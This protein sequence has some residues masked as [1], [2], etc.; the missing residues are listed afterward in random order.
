MRNMFG[1][2]ILLEIKD[3]VSEKLNRISRSMENVQTEAERTARTVDNLGSQVDSTSSS[4][5]NTTQAFEGLGSAFGR[6]DSYS[7]KL[8]R[9]MQKLA[10]MMG[11]DVPES[12]RQ[13]YQEMFNLQREV[14]R[15]RRAF[16]AYSH[17]AMEARN[18]LAEFGLGLDDATFKQVYMRSQLGLNEHQLHA[19]ANSI[20]LNARMIKLMGSETEILTKRMQGLQRHGIKPE[21]MLPRSTIGQFQMLNETMKASQQPINMLNAG[22][23]RFGTTMEKHIKSWSAQKTAIRLAQ[24][25]MV[26]YG[27][28]LRGLTA[29]TAN[30]A[31]AFPLVGMGALLA[32]G[33]LFKVTMNANKGLQD[34]ADTTK[35]KLLKAFEPLIDVTAKFLEVAMKVVGKVAD[36]ISAFNEAH[37][38]IAKVL[39]VIG[40]LAPAM[41]LLLLPLGLGVGLIN[42]WG[43]A[44]N[45]LWTFIGPVV[46]MIGTASA[47]FLTF[48]GIVG[49]VV[50]AIGYLWK[51]CEGFRK[52]I[53]SVASTISGLVTGAF[54]SLKSAVEQVVQAFNEGGLSGALS[55]TQELFQAFV[56]KIGNEAPKMIENGVKF[57]TSFLQGLTQKL[58]EI[59]TKAHEMVTKITEGIT[60][61]L[62][63]IMESAVALIQAWITNMSNNIPMVVDCG[64]AII[65]A[66]MDGIAQVAPLWLDTVLQLFT[67][68][69]QILTENLP[70][71]LDCGIQILQSL[72]NGILQNIPMIIDAVV[73]ILNSFTLLI[74]QNLPMLI[75]AG[76]QILQG[77][78]NAI[79]QNLPMLID[80]ALQLLTTIVNAIVQNLPLLINAGLQ[81]VLTLLNALVNNGPQLMQAGVQLI[82]SVVN[83]IVNSLPQI[84][85]CAIQVVTSLLT[86]IIQNAPR[87]LMGGIQL[88]LSLIKGLQQAKSQAV[89][90]MGQVITQMIQKIPSFLG[91]MGSMG[92]QLVQGLAKGIASGA[93]AVVSAIG[94]VV[95]GAIEAGK[96]FLGIHSPSR[97]FR[98]MIGRFIPQGMAVGIKA[99][100]PKVD[101]AVM[102]MTTDPIEEAQKVVMSREG[103]IP[104]PIVT[105]PKGTGGSTNNKEINNTF[106]VNITLDGETK[107]PKEHARQIYEE[108]KRLQNLDDSMN[109]DVNP[110]ELI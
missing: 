42:G 41:T 101:D 95:Q 27:I 94:N 109:Y 80:C 108:L 55:K 43:V 107:D 98:D 75:E 46:T 63:L 61:N 31:L 66:L 25:D 96:K 23:R 69:I 106:H 51:N 77:L 44:L 8:E 1:I 68:F 45:A 34:L 12:T 62:P 16:G 81:I 33:T 56:I 20:K 71:L 40:F 67:T 2:G 21:M 5:S 59:T 10:F 64:I 89:S 3:K 92:L 28:I 38:A 36:W 104:S 102:R 82:L 14:Q 53:T 13:A 103:T 58:P 39:A 65:R 78:V 22:Y 86:A 57:I 110:Q 93:S 99:E 97:V 76:I 70:L 24:G 29:G 90:A 32:Y 72:V 18:R 26:R 54:N 84:L 50:L 11:G 60:Q 85:N 91:Q 37:P 17:Q 15:S 105:P 7:R 49:A 74:A 6:T 4:F 83:G 30:L 73:Q 35:N 88:I 87:L 79:V 19:Q 48:A 9:Q 47:T 100:A 52:V